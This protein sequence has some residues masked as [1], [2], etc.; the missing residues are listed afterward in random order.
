M[1]EAEVVGRGRAD[2]VRAA[3]AV[4]WRPAADRTDGIE[5]AL[6]HRPRYD[7][8]S[9]PK[10]KLHDDEHPLVAALREVTEETGFAAV[11][12]RPLGVTRYLVRQDG[13]T[14]PKEVRWWAA[15]AQEGR[16]VP[17]DEV[18]E[19]RWADPADAADLLGADG[20]PALL[21]FLDAPPATR[22]VVLVRH[23][24]AG[25]KRRWL[26]EDDLRPLDDRGR[27]QAQQLAEV[28]ACYGPQRVL[29][30]PP[31]RCVET[32]RPLADR[33]GLAVQIEAWLGERAHAQSPRAA[34]GR[35]LEHA[36]GDDSVV[37]CSQGAVLAD[38]LDA[39]LPGASGV[40]SPGQPAKGTAFVLSF[41][42]RSGPRL[43][44]AEQWSGDR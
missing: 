39:L 4:L 35:V 17:G 14:V 3:G 11:P 15:A 12:G 31:V 44:G 43:V 24:R 2:L 23:G 19:L 32:V 16:F 1:P 28:L 29:A 9:L 25:D 21:R 13:R 37:L 36:A 5:I 10:G 41:A 30:A 6:V 26:G 38:L 18:D 33:T 22:T 7:D 34:L 20:A 40:P 42:G 8:W 27:R